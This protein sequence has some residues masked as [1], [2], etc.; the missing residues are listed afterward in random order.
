MVVYEN[1]FLNFSQIFL[2]KVRLK[3]K[4][5]IDCKVISLISLIRMYLCLYT[6]QVLCGLPLSFNCPCLKVVCVNL[7]EPY[8]ITIV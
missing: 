6:V 4:F 5:L 8:R 2:S 1:S 3:N 7:Q